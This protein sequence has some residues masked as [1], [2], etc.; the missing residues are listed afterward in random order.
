MRVRAAV[1]ASVAAFAFVAG[2]AF[3]AG[4]AE[5]APG[6]L[7]LTFGSGGTVTTDFPGHN[8]W[9]GGVVVQ[10]DGK[11]VVAGGGW[12]PPA[13]HNTGFLLVRYNVDGSLDTGF[14]R[15]GRV[16]TSSF[17]GEEVD[18]SAI[19]LQPDGKLVVAGQAGYPENGL[20][21][22]AVA[23]YTADGRLD[24]TFSGDGNVITNFIRG[25]ADEWAA[26]VAIQANGKI[27][28]AGGGGGAFAVARYRP[29]GRLDA[30]FDGD[31]KAMTRF[32]RSAEARDVA[33]QRD[34][35]IVAA[36]RV[37]NRFG[38]VRYG[39]SG[40]L[41]RSF[42]GDGRV[43]TRFGSQ[44]FG[45]GVAVQANG[46]IV[47]AGTSFSAS[48]RA[49]L[50]RYLPDGG[51]DPLFSGDGKTATHPDEGLSGNDVALDSTGSIVVAGSKSDEAGSAGF[52]LVRF[53]STGTRD[54]SF[55]SDGAAITPLD[56]FATAV[57]TAADGKIVVAGSL[58][59]DW[60]YEDETGERARFATARYHGS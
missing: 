6:D 17:G 32:R 14:G 21:K 4:A 56:G 15:G 22:F 26:G 45:N 28:V 60:D 54:R 31:G 3:L 57:A 50:A 16:V 42:G 46:R 18:G 1:I 41:D 43:T 47:V 19:A 59:G 52:A 38:L 36:G 5:A 33:I 58:S 9:A 44:S 48:R 39:R 53:T 10:P 8:A 51:L 24:R 34:G 55:G 13:G 2:P 35:K 20:T 49:V 30:T 29:N 27:V 37:G 25:Q 40:R 11:T 23:R 7:D 12:D